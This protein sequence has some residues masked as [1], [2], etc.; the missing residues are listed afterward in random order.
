MRE[1]AEEVGTS[2]NAAFCT[3][4]ALERQGLVSREYA[5]ARSLKLTDAG[6]AQLAGEAA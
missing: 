1:V 4:N 5:T 6:R 2:P 3:I